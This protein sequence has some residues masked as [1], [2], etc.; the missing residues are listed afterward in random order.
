MVIRLYVEDPVLN[1][2]LW[3]CGGPRVFCEFH[4][5]DPGRGGD[6]DDDDDACLV[7]NL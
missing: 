3:L 6:D 7:Q 4:S 5:Q 2:E 1:P